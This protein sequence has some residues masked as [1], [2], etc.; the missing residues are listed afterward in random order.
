MQSI[1]CYLLYTL[2]QDR[3]ESEHVVKS[4]VF[5]VDVQLWSDV[6]QWL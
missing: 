4:L 6:R 1:I 2:F 5:E 3:P